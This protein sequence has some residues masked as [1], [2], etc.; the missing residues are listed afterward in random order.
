[1]YLILEAKDASVR[2]EALEA[3]RRLARAQP[4]LVTQLYRE[5]LVSWLHGQDAHQLASKRPASDEEESFSSKAQKIGQLLSALLASTAVDQMALGDRAVDFLVIA[6]HPEISE[7]AR[8]SWISLLQAAGLD[9]ATVVM[10]RQEQVS[11]VIWDAAGAPPK[12]SFMR[13]K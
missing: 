2:H 7:E 6:H 10:D 11:K 9:P 3:P 4:K 13:V 8:V 12:V 1:M 5:G